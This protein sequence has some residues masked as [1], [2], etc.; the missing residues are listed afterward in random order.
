MNHNTFK[1]LK[2]YVNGVK[3]ENLHTYLMYK[4]FCF[5]LAENFKK[6]K[7][8]FKIIYCGRCQ[9]SIRQSN[10]HFLFDPSFYSIKVFDYF[11]YIYKR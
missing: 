10:R 7:N 1:T 3:N 11:D 8:Q 4:A 9:T 6:F 2:V 5:R